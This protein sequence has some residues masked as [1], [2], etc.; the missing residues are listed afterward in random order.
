MLR[1]T[2]ISAAMAFLLPFGGLRA[3][4]SNDSTNT[5]VPGST[6]I[7]DEPDEEINTEA[8][9]LVEISLA[10]LTDGTRDH[11]GGSAAAPFEPPCAEQGS[12][13]NGL[14]DVYFYCE[15]HFVCGGERVDD[16][17]TG[18]RSSTDASGFY[19][20]Y[21]SEMIGL[22]GG[23][24]GAVDFTASG[25]SVR[26]LLFDQGLDTEPSDQALPVFYYCRRDDSDTIELFPVADPP[27]AIDL[28][29]RFAWDTSFGAE[30]DI[31]AA[32]GALLDELKV[33]LGLYKPVPETIPPLATEH[34]F[35][36][37]PT[38]LWLT[39]PIETEEV[40]SES[41][42]GTIHIDI[43]ARLVQV[44][45]LFRDDVI[46]DEVFKECEPGDM[47][48]H[49]PGMHPWQDRPECIVR[50]SKLGTYELS[51]TMRYVIEERVMFRQSA[52]I[53]FVPIPFTEHPT[54]PEAALTTVVGDYGVHEIVAV[55]AYGDPPVSGD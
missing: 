18:D 21:L 13:S 40:W 25:D 51:A 30:Y 5:E 22:V 1:I 29:P 43:R 52:L 32:R 47:K 23:D 2:L 50:F 6:E 35:V 8:R 3:S 36:H 54:E 20:Q 28:S 55:N 7:D 46:D 15:V 27:T 53:P 24:A 33:R 37:F 34:T 4:A 41:D 11:D 44:D 9:T 17:L 16:I 10:A 42:L 14:G 19:A 12:S 48:A 49:V 39:N 45:W 31:D 38:W 26:D